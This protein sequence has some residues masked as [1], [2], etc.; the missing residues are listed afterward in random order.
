MISNGVTSPT[1]EETAYA[2]RVLTSVLSV[3]ASEGRRYCRPWSLPRVTCAVMGRPEL[4]TKASVTEAPGS[5]DCA[6]ATKCVTAADDLV[7]DFGDQRAGCRPG[8]RGGATVGHPVDPGAAG[9][10]VAAGLNSQPA[11]RCPAGRDQSAAMRV[12]SSTGMA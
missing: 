4:S 10:E 6:A 11:V 9:G 12:A 8:G 7:I 5:L 3:I 1:G 2:D